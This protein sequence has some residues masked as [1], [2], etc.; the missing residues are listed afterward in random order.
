MEVDMDRQQQLDSLIAAL[1]ATPPSRGTVAEVRESFEAFAANR[2]LDPDVTIE[3]VT[4]GGRP[5]VRVRAGSRGTGSAASGTTLLYLHGGGYVVGSGRTGVRLA[6]ALARRT[7][8]TTY[9]LDYRLAPEHPYPAALDD[10]LAAYREL[11]ETV[12]AAR[13]TVAGDSA[14]GGL[15]VALLVAARAAGLPQPAATAVFSPWADLTLTGDS[16]GTRTGIDPLFDLD[17]LRWYADKYVP[18]ATGQAKA[19]SPIFDDLSRTSPLL[20]QVGS[21]EVLLD[22]AVRLA[23]RA[24]AD[25]VEVT[26]EVA[27]GLPHVY[28]NSYGTLDD[29]DEALD[30]AATFLTRP[31]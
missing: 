27:A 30:R 11:L 17:A 29:A 14:G 3:D 2:A 7:G 19:A 24:A 6:A 25:D 22:D 9:S 21:A 28:Q 5:A 20:V 16:M 13:L 15:A 1:A 18:A 26:L 4:L 31:R 10:A 8:A 12:P 23:A